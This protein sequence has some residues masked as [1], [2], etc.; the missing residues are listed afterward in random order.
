MIRFLSALVL[1]VAAVGTPA[2]AQDGRGGIG[3]IVACADLTRMNFSGIP[4][5]PTSVISASLVA[6]TPEAPS[7]CRVRGNIAPNVGF[8]LRLPVDNWNGKLFMQGCRA[9]CG[10]IMIDEANDALKRGYVTV[11]T[12]MGHTGT[13]LD[14]VWAYNNRD[15][16]IDFGYRAT[17]VTAV[18]AKAILRAFHGVNAT[19]S[20]FRGCSTGGRQGLVAAQRFP[21]DFDGIIAGAPVASKAGALNF[22]WSGKANLTDS[23]R[24]ILTP[25]HVYLIRAAVMKKCDAKDGLADGILEDP[26]ECDFDPAELQCTGLG[27]GDLIRRTDCLTET[28]VEAARKIYTGPATS[29]GTHVTPGGLMPGGELS[30]LGTIVTSDGGAGQYL[31]LA[32]N[33]LRFIAFAEDPGPAYTLD[34]FNLDTDAE[35]M[36]FMLHITSGFNPD[37]RGFR[38]RGGRIIIYHGW[39]DGTALSTVDY[40]ESATAAM[41]GPDAISDTARLFMVPGMDHCGG[42]PGVNSFDFITAIEQWVELGRAPDSLLGTHKDA[43]GNETFSRPVYPY[44]EFARYEGSKE[45]ISADGFKRQ[46]PK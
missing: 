9:Y 7:H 11:A 35:R 4:D 5:A 39:Q 40:F 38:D 43:V 46:Q 31:K 30:W 23:G 26:R 8:E 21:A 36:N 16:E 15:A 41:G 34:Q 14:T 29:D 37:L 27:S 22:Y 20:Y 6:S 32:E 44:P 18:A 10:V 12:D 17:H 2:F 1:V 19:Q 13:I 45:R 24:S 42:G 25:D 28:Q 33:N 3:P